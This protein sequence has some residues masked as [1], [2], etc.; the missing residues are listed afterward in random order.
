MMQ[1]L[2]VTIVIDL[3][4]VAIYSRLCV[5]SLVSMIMIAERVFQLYKN[6]NWLRVIPRFSIRQLNKR[7]LCVQRLVPKVIQNA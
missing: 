2:F 3:C 6:L 7:A 4:I 1:A 5:V